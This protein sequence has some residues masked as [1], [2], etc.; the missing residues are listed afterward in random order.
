M[1]TAAAR[2]GNRSP[3]KVLPGHAGG[4]EQEE[5]LATARTHGMSPVQVRLA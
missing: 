5:A 2:L 1:N 4:D 3:I